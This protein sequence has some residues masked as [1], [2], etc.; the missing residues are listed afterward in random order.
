MK[1]EGVKAG[2]PFFYKQGRY[3]YEG[4]IVKTPELD[5]RQWMEYPREERP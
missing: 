5:G 2:V 3:R 4:Q 1:A